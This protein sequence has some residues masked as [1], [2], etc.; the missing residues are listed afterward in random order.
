MCFSSSKER[1]KSEST[2]PQGGVPLFSGAVRRP[3]MAGRLGPVRRGLRVRVCFDCAPT[4]GNVLQDAAKR[5]AQL[6]AV[7]KS[8]R[9][10]WTV[11]AGI[12]V[13]IFDS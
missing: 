6:R 13:A 3:S 2:P 10:F 5:S 4:R 9:A 12:L 8:T 11:N 7:A 1:R